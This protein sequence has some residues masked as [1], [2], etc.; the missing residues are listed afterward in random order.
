MDVQHRHSP[1]RSLRER[2]SSCRLRSWRDPDAILRFN[3]YGLEN[4]AKRKR[5]ITLI[6]S[7]Q[8]QKVPVHAIG[9]QAHLNVSITS[10]TMDQT[11]AEISTLS[12]PIH[13]I[14]LA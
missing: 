8:A 7:L 13:I 10:E 1:H 3:D 2:A 14:E 12:V 9:S 5:L 4:P 6:E 11:L